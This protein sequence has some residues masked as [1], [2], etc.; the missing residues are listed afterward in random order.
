MVKSGSPLFVLSLLSK[1]LEQAKGNFE[2]VL[3]V[4]HTFFLK[5]YTADPSL[6]VRL[7]TMSVVERAD[8][9]VS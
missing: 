6:R 2:L 3:T 9:A 1:H 4:F 5:F 7:L 8:R